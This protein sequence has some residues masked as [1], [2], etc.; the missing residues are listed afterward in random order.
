MRKALTSPLLLVPVLGGPAEQVA[1]SAISSALH[2]EWKLRS[3]SFFNAP[4]VAMLERFGFG[5]AKAAKAEDGGEVLWALAEI[6]LFW[7]KLPVSQT[8]RA[9]K[10][11]SDWITGED[12]PKDALDSGSKLIFGNRPGKPE[13]PFSLAR[14]YV[15]GER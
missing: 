1:G 3:P 8:K 15:E 11:L 4:A 2:G 10:S 9:G 6:A 5:L 12:E 14:D 13:D 7:R